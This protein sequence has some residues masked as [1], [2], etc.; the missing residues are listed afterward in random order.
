M[1]RLTSKRRAEDPGMEIVSNFVLDLNLYIIV[2]MVDGDL[3][4]RFDRVNNSDD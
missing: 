2:D 4:A 3:Y 1:A